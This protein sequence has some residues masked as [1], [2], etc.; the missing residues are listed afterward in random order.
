MPSSSH[1]KTCPEI[2]LDPPYS[3][4][5]YYLSYCLSCP[6]L[7]EDE[8]IMDEFLT[9]INELLED[10]SGVK[11]AKTGWYTRMITVHGVFQ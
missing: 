6:I 9:P 1:G 8:G 5:S 2:H 3:S 11:E 10:F 7:Q 4:I